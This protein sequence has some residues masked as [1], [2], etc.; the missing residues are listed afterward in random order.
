[1]VQIIDGRACARQ[2]KKLIKQE[3]GEL[4]KPLIPRLAIIQIANNPASEVYVRA[5]IKQAEEI[6]ISAYA[7]RFSDTI[8]QDN[9]IKLIET[10]NTDDSVNGMIVQLPLPDHLDSAT[11]LNK[12]SPHKD[13]DG[14]SVMNVGK[15]S[16]GLDCLVPCTPLGCLILLESKFGD[17]TGKKAAIIGRSNLV[18]KP[19]AQLL[20]QKNCSV[21]VVHSKSENPE[22]ITRD[23]DIVISAVGKPN[24]VTDKWIKSGSILIDVGINRLDN[25]MLVGDI[26]FNSVEHKAGYLTPVPGGVG[27]MTVACLLLNTVIAMAKQN[28]LRLKYLPANPLVEKICLS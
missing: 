7:L 6:G 14:L 16:M 1:M 25:G 12:I 10:L 4:S 9:V 17:L 13:V 11:I 2:L 22:G 3:L 18:G 19:L 23:A 26:D 24:F 28:G 20:L 15:L 5:K 21:S 27:P 8:S